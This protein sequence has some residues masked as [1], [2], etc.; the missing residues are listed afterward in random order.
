MK[1]ERKFGE[2]SKP[3]GGSKTNINLSLYAMSVRLGVEVKLHSFLP[4]NFKFLSLCPGSRVP[5][6][7][8]TG[9]VWVPEPVWT[10][11]GREK[12]SWLWQESNHNFP[13]V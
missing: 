10:F 4:P 7:H 2:R 9:V 6:N 3:V 13:A 11:W 1:L 8:S 12:F 5:D